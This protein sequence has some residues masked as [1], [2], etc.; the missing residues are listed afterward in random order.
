MEERLGPMTALKAVKMIKPRLIING[1]MHSGGFK[2]HEFPWGSRYIYIDSS[3]Q[4]RHYLVVEDMEIEVWRDLEK[5]STIPLD[6]TTSSH[7]RTS[8]ANF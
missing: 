6:K 7:A 5:I 3:Q 2:A 1:H 8:P 4:N